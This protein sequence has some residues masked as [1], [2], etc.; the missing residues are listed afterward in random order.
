MHYV[1]AFIDQETIKE[2]GDRRGSVRD[3]RP[4]Q[5][6]TKPMAIDDVSRRG[7][8]GQWANEA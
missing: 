3:V 8:G 1:N 4:E 6:A 5:A 2:C 7:R